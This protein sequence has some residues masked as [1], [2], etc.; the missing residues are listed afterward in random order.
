[1]RYETA[2][3]ANNKTEIPKDAQKKKRYLIIRKAFLLSPLG[4]GE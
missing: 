2:T 1:M 4:W 3:P